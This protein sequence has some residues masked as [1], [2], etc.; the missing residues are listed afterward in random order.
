MKSEQD[1]G[2]DSYSVE[3]EEYAARTFQKFASEDIGKDAP[4]H[5]LVLSCNEAI[6]RG[7]IEAGVRVAAAYPGSPL[8]YVLENLA[9]AARLYPSMHVEWSTNEKCAFEVALAASMAGVRGITALKNVGMHWLLDP[10]VACTVAGPR[11]LV[12]VVGDDP[13]A[14]TTMHEPDTRY[15]AMYSELPVLEPSTC[16]EVK[17]FIP[18][19]F[20]LS[21]SLWVPVYVRVTSRLGYSREVVEFGSINHEIRE[22]EAHFSRDIVNLYRWCCTKALPFPYNQQVVRHLRFHDEARPDIE[23]LVGSLPKA[24][25]I[26]EAIDAMPE[27]RLTLKEGAKIG[28]ITA[29][30][31][32]GAVMEAL[33]VFGI[34]D[35][36]AV[37]KLAASYPLP[38]PLVDRLLREMETVVVIEEIEPFIENQVRS[39]TAG[40]KD[41]AT[42]LGK[43]TGHLPYSGE[44]ERNTVGQL[45]A[46]LMGREFSIPVSAEEE[47][48]RDAMLRDEVRVDKVQRMCPGCPSFAAIYTLKKVCQ[49]LEIA[50]QVIVTG[51]DG[52]H[53]LS[54]VEP[55]EFEQVISSMGA[56]LGISN[57]FSH[58]GMK[59]KIVAIIGDSTFFH[60]GLPELVNAVYNKSNLLLLVLDNR[61]T[62]MTGH[63]PHPGGFGITATG[64]RTKTLNIEDFARASKADF[65][66]VVNPY[67]Y[68]QTYD[69]LKAALAREGV[70]V[71]V[72]RRV[73]ALVAQ[74]QIGRRL[75]S[76]TQSRIN[77]ETCLSWKDGSCH[78]CLDDFGCLAMVA[79]ENTP[80]GIRSP[81]IDLEICA[82]CKVCAKM[83][84]HNAIEEVEVPK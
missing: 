21:E 3:T 77:R 81:E 73:C 68:E 8:T 26:Q 64:E 59:E 28:V 65:V 66:D 15:V 54:A 24:K 76:R 70:S 43:V 7:A 50:D 45:L 11:G 48:P 51:D 18:L 82:A 36:A 60:A 75:L 35:A 57:G 29:G 78:I 38:L 39:R 32:Y 5:T 23:Q 30:L 79:N 22:R 42:I 71:V 47:E 49:D 56:G 31:A 83:C 27:N 4:G 44:V 69:I 13:G 61:T 9:I 52:C 12:M 19:A 14:E 41:H 72:A 58:L 80:L 74:R 67:N 34:A 63:Q 2:R 53:A 62:A 33:D 20:E 17:D 46:E 10:L 84:P 25:A 1:I 6:A 40:M 16:Q 55:L 37:L